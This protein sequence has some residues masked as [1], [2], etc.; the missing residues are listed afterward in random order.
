MRLR[1]KI[2]LLLLGAGALG[3]ALLV[4]LPWREMAAERLQMML[5]QA[6][7][8]KVQLSL[9]SLGLRGSVLEH[10][11]IGAEP[12]LVLAKVTLDYDPQALW[13]GRLHKLALSG[14]ALEL[15]DSA[16]GWML[17]GL[18]RADNNARQGAAK[19]LPYF[20]QAELAAVPLRE[21][22]LTDSSL[23]VVAPS[24]Q[25]A[26]PLTLHWRQQPAP[27]LDY[28]G[29]DLRVSLALATAVAQQASARLTHDAAK[30]EWDGAWQMK[31][32][33]VQGFGG[34]LPV[35]QGSGTLKANARALTVA[36]TLRGPDEGWQGR[37][38]YHQPLTAGAGRLT[39]AQ[40]Q[41]PWQGGRIIV[42]DAVAPLDGR[43]VMRATVEIR[44]VALDEVL[45]D[46]TGKRA[47]G[48]G[49]VSGV[50]PVQRLA[51]GTLI[52]E[53]GHLAADAPGSIAVTPDLIPGDNPQI[54]LLRDL[55]Q[56]LRYQV[57]SLGFDSGADHKLT[58]K[59]SLEGHNPAVQNGKPVK[60][61]INLSGDVLDVLQHNL[62]AFTDPRKLA[63]TRDHEK[64]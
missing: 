18:H 20:T 15:R 47:S 63:P 44:Q 14:M 50:L 64:K 43:G 2:G 61:N 56:D 17:M 13:D 16:E 34:M 38:T 32:V 19:P 11:Q 23:S 49:T 29:Q 27:R 51:D 30:A 3:G 42:R 24:W 36:G 7:G 22:V 37:F 45:R 8:Q 21:G 53:G 9:S 25:A 4:A 52:V 48:K 26:L 35:M 58:I 39:V 5:G 41:M 31:D 33:T 54:A 57:L 40:A 46:A 12:P 62:T 1:R 28:E 6:L 59:L 60:L 55:L 10:V